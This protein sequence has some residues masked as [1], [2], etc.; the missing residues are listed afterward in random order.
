MWW[1]KVATRAAATGRPVAASTT[2]PDS[3]DSGVRKISTVRAGA[4]GEID[5]AGRDPQMEAAVRQTARSRHPGRLT[6]PAVPE[7]DG[8]HPRPLDRSAA[9]VL[10]GAG[11]LDPTWQQGD[12]D[13]APLLAGGQRDRSVAASVAVPSGTEMRRRGLDPVAARSEPAQAVTSVGP[14]RRAHCFTNVTGETG[15]RG[16]G[17]RAYLGRDRR[18]RRVAHGSLDRT[19][20]NRD[21]ADER[22]TLPVRAGSPSRPRPTR[23]SAVPSRTARGP[24]RR[25]SPDPQIAVRAGPCRRLPRCP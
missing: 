20:H 1:G 11:Q 19:A 25:L 24:V 7:L 23:V 17:R 5:V 3:D 14:S 15:S 9:Q 10:H 21:H 6:R 18:T 12:V 4:P 13:V 22:T 8:A 16:K 2:S